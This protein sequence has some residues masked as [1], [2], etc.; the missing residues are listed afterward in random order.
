MFYKNN[1]SQEMYNRFFKTANQSENIKLQK[2][3]KAE[4]NRLTLIA[5][6]YLSD[7]Q[8][9]YLRLNSHVVKKEYSS[10]G[11]L[12]SRGFYCPSPIYDIV[13]G[14]CKRGKLLKRVTSRNRP[15]YEYCF[16]KNDKLIIVNHLN[17]NSS[18]TLEYAG[19]SVIGIT[20]SKEA[21]PEITSVIECKYDNNGRIISY[22]K[23]I[24]SFNDC[25]IDQL[26][27]EI[28]TYSDLGLF[29]AEVFDYLDDSDSGILNFCKYTFE[30]DENGY[31][32]EYK[33]ETS[34]FEDDIYKVNIKR[35]I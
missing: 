23:A 27:K 3:F 16:D 25:C 33:V 15:T 31:L 8:D 29:Q 20:F 24:S 11:E 32:K 6:K 9:I 12:I 30:H 35:K 14:N 10:G 21:T 22:I 4:C 13:T 7:C 2:E 1:N 28:Y 34:I 19:N 26:E 17:E 5:K 18:E